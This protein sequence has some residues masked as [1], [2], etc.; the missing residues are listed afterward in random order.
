MTMGE[1]IV[2]FSSKDKA[3]LRKVLLF[4]V[5]K[6]SAQILTALFLLTGLY[7]FRNHTYNRFFIG[8]SLMLYIGLLLGHFFLDRTRGRAARLI[9]DWWLGKKRVISGPVEQAVFTDKGDAIPLLHYKIGPYRFELSELSPL[10]KKFR[11]VMP[12]ECVEVHQCLFSGTVLRI[13]LL[14]QVQKQQAN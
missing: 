14:E 6:F 5:F 12:G 10:L 9:R 7:F 2:P 8:A 3:T 1:R 4:E 13:R 11:Q